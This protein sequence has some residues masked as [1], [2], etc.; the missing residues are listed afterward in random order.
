[1]YLYLLTGQPGFIQAQ[2]VQVILLPAIPHTWAW[3]AVR[4]TLLMKQDALPPS[5]HGWIFCSECF[6][7]HFWSS[8][9]SQGSLVTIKIDD[10]YFWVNELQIYF[11]SSFFCFKEFWCLVDIVTRNDLLW[12]LSKPRAIYEI[13]PVVTGLVDFDY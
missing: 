12:L 7:L 10:K 5:H 6:F 1:M 4:V 13:D 3:C 9:S 11:S 2:L 8:L